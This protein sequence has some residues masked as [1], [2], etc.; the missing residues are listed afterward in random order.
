M[1]VIKGFVVIRG[2]N[3]T[4]EYHVGGCSPNLFKYCS[5]AVEKKMNFSTRKAGSTVGLVDAQYVFF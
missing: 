1:S 2:I 4:Q 3:W 5:G